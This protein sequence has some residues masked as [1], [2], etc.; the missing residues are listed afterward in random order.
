[1]AKIGR[2]TKYNQEILK[3]TTQYL[4]NYEEFGDVIPSIAGLA[5]CLKLPRTRLYDWA[6]HENKKEFRDMLQDILAKQEQVLLNKG[7]SGEFN[8]NIAKLALAKHGYSDRQETNLTSDKPTEP[9]I[10]IKFVKP[11]PL[12]TNYL[13][14]EPELKLVS[15]D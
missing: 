5:V 12:P 15:K 13:P 14:D 8:S 2:P 9:A 1:M 10:T 4:N 3:K 11:D 6:S 7:L